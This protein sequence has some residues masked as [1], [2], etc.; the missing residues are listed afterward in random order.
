MYQCLFFSHTHT[1]T[2]YTGDA[3][4]VRVA[5]IEA[6]QKVRGMVG[7]HYHDFGGGVSAGADP[8][9]AGHLIMKT[10]LLLRLL[11]FLVL[12]RGDP[13]H[14]VFECSTLFGVWSVYSGPYDWPLYYLLTL[15]SCSN[16]SRLF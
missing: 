14:Q 11:L 13:E 4:D 5:G 16:W 7:I 15:F 3:E 6:V 12:R 8:Y 10:L 9:S 1:Q 2:W